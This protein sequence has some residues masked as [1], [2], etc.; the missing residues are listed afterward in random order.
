MRKFARSIGSEG[1]VRANQQ[2]SVLSCCGYFSVVCFGTCYL[3]NADGGRSRLW[4]LPARG[5]SLCS[6]SL[7][8]GL[9]SSFGL[10][11]VFHKLPTQNCLRRGIQLY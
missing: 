3:S 9:A 4:R 8:H 2:V 10:L 7:W 5:G 11:C 6:P 1:K